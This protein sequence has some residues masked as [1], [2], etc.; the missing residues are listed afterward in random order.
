MGIDMNRMAVTFCAML[1]AAMSMSMDVHAQPRDCLIHTF[2][3]IQLTDEYWS[4]GSAV[5]DIDRDGHM[6]VIAPPFWYSGPDFKTRHTFYP[7]DH[8]FTV[9]KADG[10]TK[11]IPGFDGGV[12]SEGG[13]FFSQSFF[14][15]AGDF[16]GDGWQDILVVA[17]SNLRPTGALS[18]PE[19]PRVAAYWYENPGK[20]GLRAGADWK[21][22]LIADEISSESIQLVDLFKDGHPVLLG[23][24][25]HRMGYFRPDPQDPYKPWI[26]YPISEQ[27]D[28][29]E[30][31]NHGLGFGDLTNSGR[32]DVLYN[33][34]WW[35]Q[36][37]GDDPTHRW[38]FFPYPFQ[39]GPDEVKINTYAPNLKLSMNVDVDADGVADLFHMST[40]GGSRMYVYDIN[41]D[42]LPDIVTSLDAHKYGLVW[43]EQLKDRDPAGNI[44]FKR[45]MLIYKK[46][47][48]NKYGLVLTEM[49]ALVLADMDGDGLKDILTGKQFWAEG[50]TGKPPQDPEPNAPAAL[51]WF[52]LVRK[53]D[54]TVDFIPYMIDNDSGTGNQLTV[55][56]INGD[57]LPDV[58]TAGKKGAFV[59]VHQ[60]KKVT[61][62]EWMKAQPPVLYPG[63]KQ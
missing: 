16:N 35:K 25:Q 7:A 43:W 33:D 1:V 37:T 18:I 10:T 62:D 21:R 11:T 27:S 55:T 59:F 54:G 56:D 13:R 23:M 15:A 14:A 34:G 42:G 29:Y 47:S 2:K 46:P 22:H 45:H 36:Q 20:K 4:D 50:N 49:Q 8:S 39:I 61:K 9:T 57:G 48:D 3:K 12:L 53:A 19:V 41:G 52:K 38:R 5:A 32:N 60:V 30:W 6:D 28:E 58:V 40:Y 31:Y 63:A 24:H 51:Y 17:F 44:L 26:F